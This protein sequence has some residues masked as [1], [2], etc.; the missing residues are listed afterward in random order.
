[1]VNEDRILTSEHQGEGRHSCAIS[2]AP[3]RFQNSALGMVTKPLEHM[4]NLM[5]HGVRQERGHIVIVQV[6]SQHTVVK[7][8]SVTPFQWQSHA[9]G[10][11]EISIRSVCLKHQENRV[12]C[13]GPADRRLVPLE[14]HSDLGKHL[15]GEFLCRIHYK[16]IGIGYEANGYSRFQLLLVGRNPEQIPAEH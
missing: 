7:H 8:P 6:C 3:V 16:A 10:S 13:A 4:C 15:A 11:G 1:M 5:C 14:S 2:A 12:A 9:Q